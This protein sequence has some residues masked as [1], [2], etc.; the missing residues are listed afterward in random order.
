[1]SLK[2]WAPECS[3]FNRKSTKYFFSSVTPLNSVFRVG[4][5]NFLS[6]ASE[7]CSCAPKWKKGIQMAP[8]VQQPKLL[9]PG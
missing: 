2:G 8:L 7:L 4:V 6:G 3:Q 5:G 9:A 1:M